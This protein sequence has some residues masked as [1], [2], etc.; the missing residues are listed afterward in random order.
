[1]NLKWL[2][3]SGKHSMTSFLDLVF[4]FSFAWFSCIPLSYL[5]SHNVSIYALT[6]H[7]VHIVVNQDFFAVNQTRSDYYS[8]NSLGV[9]MWWI[10][11]HGNNVGLL[12]LSTLLSLSTFIFVLLTSLFFTFY[13]VWNNITIRIT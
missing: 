12:T 7:L 1:M 6:R 11:L 5:H 9:I 8:V 10:V 4:F 3:E 2:M 13:L